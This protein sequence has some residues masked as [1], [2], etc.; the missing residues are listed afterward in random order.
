MTQIIGADGNPAG[1]IEPGP[2]VHVQPRNTLVTV[3]VF[4]PSERRQGSIVVP[5]NN[6]EYQEG[7][8]IAVGRGIVAAG[9]GNSGTED[10]SPGQRVL[11]KTQRRTAKG[12]MNEG[13]PIGRFDGEDIPDTEMF[14]FEEQNIIAILTTPYA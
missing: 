6:D 11:V 13:L 3:R 8:I 12:L 14:I 10:L 4:K 5:A 9:G 2:T 1:E 7:E